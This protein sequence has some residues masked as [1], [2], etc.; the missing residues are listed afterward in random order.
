M[1]TLLFI[2][3]DLDLLDINKK[4]FTQKGYLVKVLNNIDF[5]ERTLESHKIDCILLDIMMPQMSGFEVIKKIKNFSNIPI[6]FVSGLSHIDNKIQGLSLG[7]NDY[8]TKPYD[9]SELEARIK[10]QIR[11]SESLQ[12]TD[13]II[14]N[15]LCIDT[16][17]HKAYIDS[18]DLLL[19][20]RE[21]DLL[22]I[23][24]NVPKKIV[25]YEEISRKF[26]NNYTE[27]DK[28]TIMA[29]ASRLRKKI[30][31]YSSRQDSIESIRSTGYRFN[32]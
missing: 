13:K 32:P 16:L 2:D 5:L 30:S 19:T 31:N 11:I 3:D 25:T 4:I 10:V 22:M 8:I 26:W 9:Y 21:F 29:T 12:T 18:N 17:N 7:G 6:I 20:N 24:V 23:L 28:N 15:S 27:Q 14:H 1:K